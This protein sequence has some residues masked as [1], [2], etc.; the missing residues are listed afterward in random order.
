MDIQSLKD[1]VYG[2]GPVGKIVAAGHA[3]E[4][5]PTRMMLARLCPDFSAADGSRVAG[6]VSAYLDALEAYERAIFKVTRNDHKVALADDAALLNERAAQWFR[7]LP[8]EMRHDARRQMDGRDPL[9]L[10]RSLFGETSALVF[11]HNFF[12]SLDPTAFAC[13][14]RVRWMQAAFD[15]GVS[16]HVISQDMSSNTA[17]DTLFGDLY[18]RFSVTDNTILHLVNSNEERV[19]AEWGKRAFELVKDEEFEICYSHAQFVASHVAGRLYKKAHPDTLWIAEIGDPLYMHVDGA[20]RPPTEEFVGEEA[21]L[22]TFWR[23][24]EAGTLREADVIIFH[25]DCLRDFVL[26]CNPD[27]EAARL[28]ADKVALA[29]NRAID[30]RCAHLVHVPLGLDESRINIAYLGSFA[31]TR[32]FEPLD[33]VLENENVEL[34]LF[35]AMNWTTAPVFDK[36]SEEARR[37]VHICE[38]VTHLE[39]LNVCSQMDYCMVNDTLFPRKP[40]PYKPSKYYDYIAAGRPV[41]A[42]TQEGSPI[43]KDSYEKLIRAH[44]PEEMHEIALALTKQP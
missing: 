32:P 38:P 6:T 8:Q 12:P 18:G 41:I 21:H 5:R 25:N 34:Y 20:P 30:S 24:V 43:D 29:N 13:T 33:K 3:L 36:L 40:N 39:A 4:L 10:N 22:N 17:V 14:K 19:A 11:S 16:W 23:D 15:E 2:I 1:R 7:R 35:L 44:T 26:E 9:F 42:Y 37:R 28:A 27:R 31:P